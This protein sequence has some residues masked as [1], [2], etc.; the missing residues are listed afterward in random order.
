MYQFLGCLL[1]SSLQ[2][3]DGGGYAAYFRDT[4]MKVELSSGKTI[5]IP[6]TQG[7]MASILAKCKMSLNRFKQIR[8]AFHPEHKLDSNGEDDKCYQIRGA[9]NE[10]NA[11]SAA[12]FVPEGNLAFDE[13]TYYTSF[14][15]VLFGVRVLNPRFHWW[16]VGGVGCRTEEKWSV[17]C[18]SFITRKTWAALTEQIR[19]ECILVDLQGTAIS[20]N[21]IRKY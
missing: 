7:F 14:L 13:G 2:P 4:N 18:R 16:Y 17:Q 12:N 3:I 21:G 19:C 20:R 6:G 10:L 1:R 8:G 15:A 5:E 9:L 11:A